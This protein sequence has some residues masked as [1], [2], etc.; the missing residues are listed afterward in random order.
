MDI[1]DQKHYYYQILTQLHR[2]YC[3]CMSYIVS[4]A[5]AINTVPLLLLLLLLL[6]SSSSSSLLLLK[7]LALIRIFK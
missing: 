2:R 4:S 7:L 3:S 6:L 1:A 5:N